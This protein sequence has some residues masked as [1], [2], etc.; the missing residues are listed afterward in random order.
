MGYYIT[1]FSLIFYSNCFI[2][3]LFWSPTKTINFF[4]CAWLT[5]INSNLLEVLVMIF[6]LKGNGLLPTYSTFLASSQ[7]TTS[8]H[9]LCYC[10]VHVYVDSS[11]IFMIVCSLSEW[12]W[13]CVCFLLFV[14]IWITVAIGDPVI[15]RG[16]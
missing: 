4:G 6:C 15:K 9:W 13:I 10:T 7:V 11:F 16:R 12:K 5:D 8:I 1:N 2:T 3:Y 14:Y